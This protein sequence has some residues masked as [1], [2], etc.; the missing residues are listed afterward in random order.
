MIKAFME[1]WLACLKEIDVATKHEAW[2]A[3]C[4]FLQYL[5]TKKIILPL[6]L[7]RFN[8]EEYLK[9][10]PPRDKMDTPTTEPNVEITSRVDG[11]T[12]DEVVNTRNDSLA[13]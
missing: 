3:P 11:G 5:L 6:T 1:G 4:P 2:N 8:E 9:Q 13:D 7:T 10:L 12:K